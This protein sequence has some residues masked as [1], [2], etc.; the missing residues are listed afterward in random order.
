MIQ[1]FYDMSVAG[2]DIDIGL[3]S[4]GIY[5]AL[6]TTVAGLVTGL[7]ANIAFNH[8]VAMIDR[9]ARWLETIIEEYAGFPF[10]SPEL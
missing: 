2:N 4:R 3:L 5:T 8:L 10:S 9:R 1:A 6:V 7:V